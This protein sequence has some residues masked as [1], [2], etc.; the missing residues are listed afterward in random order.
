MRAFD[1]SRYATGNKA[2]SSQ[3]AH[4]LGQQFGLAVIGAWHGTE[5]YDE[6][7]ASLAKCRL[8]GMVTATYA[9][10]SPNRDAR[11]AID[12]C[13]VRCG[14]EWGQLRFVAIDCETD[15]VSH[16][17]IA[18]AAV[19]ISEL[20]GY[21]IIYTSKYKWGVLT[22]GSP[23]FSHLGLFLWD[24]LYNGQADLN[25]FLSGAYGGWTW[26]SL[27]GHQYSNTTPFADISIDYNV[28][29][30][31]WIAKRKPGTELVDLLTAWQGDMKD[32]VANTELLVPAISDTLLAYHTL[33]VEQRQRAW[34]ALLTSSGQV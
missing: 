34:H 1:T 9:A 21:P 25:D 11:Q 19:R 14:S 16:D 18:S 22:G 29:S 27:A 23:D 10:L 17:Q 8:E 24:A 15:G 26:Q 2:I 5:G 31:D 30:D 20:H 6:A 7:E 32:L 12:E 28:F 33:Y 3:T 4:L 13:K